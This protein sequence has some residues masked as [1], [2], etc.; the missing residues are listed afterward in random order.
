MPLKT[1][2][3]IWQRRL[4]SSRDTH[5]RHATSVIAH[6]T[7]ILRYGLLRTAC[8]PTAMAFV[9]YGF[10]FVRVRRREQM[11]TDQLICRFISR[12][13]TAYC[14]AIELE[15]EIDIPICHRAQR[16]RTGKRGCYL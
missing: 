1:G 12:F 9:P 10:V 13:H 11:E 16:G 3:E 6:H 4:R 2:Y 15:I 14:N 8:A 5:E 7:T